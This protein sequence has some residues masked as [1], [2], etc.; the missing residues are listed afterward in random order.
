MSLSVRP[1]TIQIMHPWKIRSRRTA[2]QQPPWITV[3]LHEVELPN[4]TVIPEWAWVITPDFVNVIALTEDKQVLCFRQNK[5][6]IDGL[7]YAPVGGY[8]EPGEDP[9]VAAQREL[10]EE[11][12]YAA[13]D[14]RF[15]GKYAVD[16]NRGSGSGHLYL[17]LGASKVAEIH[18]D[19]LEEMQ[20]LTLNLDD[21][22]RELLAGEFKLLPWV[23]NAALAL[24][25]I[26]SAKL[27][28]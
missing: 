8:I 4:G 13:A 25:Y 14:W 17:A 26:R 16:G 3:E 11:T 20:L 6:A 9:L 12:G 2:L 21:F 1:L 15:L 19:D 23:A 10:H 28:V 5:Y 18:A 22:E 7:S 24:L 27:K